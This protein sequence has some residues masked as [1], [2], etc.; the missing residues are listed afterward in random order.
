MISKKR[1]L[2]S[3]GRGCRVYGQVMFM[4]LPEA[5]L[6]IWT[7][8]G[9][10]ALAGKN[11][12]KS[13]ASPAEDNAPTSVV[14]DHSH[15]SDI[16]FSRQDTAQMSQ[17]S[18]LSAADVLR[19]PAKKHKTPKSPAPDATIN[20]LTSPTLE[21]LHKN[22]QEFLAEWT[23][24]SLFLERFG[25]LRSA[26]SAMGSTREPSSLLSLATA[27][28]MQLPQTQRVNAV[29]ILATANPGLAD[30]ILSVNK[31]GYGPVADFLQHLDLNSSGVAEEDDSDAHADDGKVTLSTVHGCKGA[32][33][34]P[35]ALVPVE[36][37]PS[38]DCLC[39][40]GVAS[41]L[42]PKVH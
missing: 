8:S 14:S 27:A 19:T 7:E 28:V 36:V 1:G 6:Y 4:S 41:R 38:P 3:A 25:E 9:I 30:L 34:G 33:L 26:P 39:R 42:C 37:V 17:H 13:G 24:D 32:A 35:T 5:M 20:I 2:M 15:Q 16:S 12:K 21:A 23:A 29:N 11:R 31:C 40:S 22:S 10:S 18:G